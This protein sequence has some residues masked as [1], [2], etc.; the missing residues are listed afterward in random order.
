MLRGRALRIASWSLLTFGPIALVA[1][2][3]LYFL[4]SVRTNFTARLLATK[5]VTLKY[6][7]SAE[8]KISP[9][10]G[11]EEAGAD[12]WRGITFA[13]RRLRF[14]PIA[15]AG[16]KDSLYLVTAPEPGFIDYGPSHFN[17]KATYL[18]LRIPDPTNL[19]ATAIG[20]GA[21]EAEGYQVQALTELGYVHA[22]S[23][24]GAGPLHMETL[25][26]FPLGA[27]VPRENSKVT[28]NWTHR[29]PPLFDISEDYS[30]M[31]DRPRDDN[32][33]KVSADQNKSWYSIVD[34]LGPKVVL[35]SDRPVAVLSSSHVALGDALR[36]A[37]PHVIDVLIVDV[38]FSARVA[39]EPF[40]VV[41]RTLQDQVMGMWPNEVSLGFSNEPPPTGSAELV[42]EESPVG[43]I[44]MVRL[45]QSMQE[46]P[47]LVACGIKT[48]GL[49]LADAQDI[50]MGF[51]LPPSPQPAGFNV[52]GEVRQLTFESASGSVMIGAQRYDIDPS[53]SVSLKQ[54]SPA[55]RAVPIAIGHDSMIID[56]AFAAKAKMQIGDE[57][58]TT[59]I[60]N[61]DSFWRP[62]ELTLV[63]L[64]CLTWFGLRM[65]SLRR[66]I[67]GAP[68]P[69]PP[70]PAPR[71]PSKLATLRQPP[72]RRLR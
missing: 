15:T 62:I 58:I 45:R 39:L 19:D 13:G 33:G 10:C 42:E 72:K 29:A 17:M 48:S 37:D 34:L 16:V 5:P 25:G 3:S 14:E 31:F 26:E 23:I 21:F 24:F 67:R 20:N 64:P 4:Q 9:A 44:D 50:C 22:L 47:Q 18:Q 61:Q 2:L 57:A 60:K 28:L 32:W 55:D 11:C 46:K 66:A 43:P 63:L 8:Q 6:L 69:L 30:P 51:R 56:E 49:T 1:S 35:W 65:R 59:R 36:P 52:F 71:R 38:P 40:G 27:F 41:D 12:E 68:A 7:G 70:M 53:A 54:V